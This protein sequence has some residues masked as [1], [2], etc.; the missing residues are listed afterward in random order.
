MEDAAHSA[1]PSRLVSSGKILAS[2]EATGRMRTC[3]VNAAIHHRVTGL[4]DKIWP[5]VARAVIRFRFEVTEAT[6]PK[7]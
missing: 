1:A 2:S 6:G 7:T 5:C 4:L 3:A